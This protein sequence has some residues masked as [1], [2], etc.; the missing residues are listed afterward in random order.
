V[1][2]DG[3]CFDGS[4][5]AT[6][7]WLRFVHYGFDTCMFPSAPMR[8]IRVLDHVGMRDTW[9]RRERQGKRGACRGEGQGKGTCDAICQ[10]ARRC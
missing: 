1:D 8:W 2:S 6:G 5:P 7:G 4:G 10:F 3:V 9:A